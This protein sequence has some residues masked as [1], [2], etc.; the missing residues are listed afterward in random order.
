MKHSI[1]SQSCRATNLKGLRH[2]LALAAIGASLALASFAAT[3]QTT[4]APAKVTAP[5]TARKAPAG[6]AA[7][8]A[9]VK[10]YGSKTA[11]ITLEV[12]TDYQ[13]PSCR[14]F[15]EQ[16]LRYVIRDYVS[17]GKVYVVHHDFPLVMHQ[18][19]GQAARW[20][21]AAATVGQFETVEG[22]LYDNQQSWETDGN[23]AKYISSAMPATDFARVDAIMKD[24][25]TPAPQE[26][27][28][29]ADPLA[30]SG[31]SCPV[32]RYIADDIKLGDN[33]PVMYTPTY[34]ISYK[35][36]SLAPA[37]GAVSWPILKQFFDSLLAQ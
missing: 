11:P 2:G 4:S 9:P 16:T 30:K 19:S 13:C 17:A 5:H 26:V 3:A 33:L 1:G 27:S 10:T 6:M 29:G 14:A 28:R 36:K 31:T 22:A 37:S 8:S 21:N 35:G 25:T 12:Y 18:Y 34:V 20:A 15:F 7:V 32:D 23:I 24:C